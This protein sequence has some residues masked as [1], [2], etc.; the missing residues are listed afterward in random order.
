MKRASINEIMNIKHVFLVG[1]G[2]NENIQQKLESEANEFSDMIMI[3]SNE[4]YT[5][6]VQKHFA[7]IEWSIDYCANVSYA[8]KLTFL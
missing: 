7:L 5:N 4:N 1:K 6:I 3:D 8:I 2:E